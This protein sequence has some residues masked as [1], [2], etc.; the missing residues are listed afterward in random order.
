MGVRGE[1]GVSGVEAPVVGLAAEMGGAGDAPEGAS[2]G[3]W[4]GR[5]QLH[6]GVGA[7]GVG[8][9]GSWWTRVGW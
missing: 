1:R 8:R 3:V 7:W 6:L 4:W 9:V 2:G 5:V